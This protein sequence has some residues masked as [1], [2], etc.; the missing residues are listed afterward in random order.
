M[1]VRACEFGNQWFILAV[2]RCT[3]THSQLSPLSRWKV[4][5][6]DSLN[7]YKTDFILTSR[8]FNSTTNE[9][10][11]KLLERLENLSTLNAQLSHCTIQSRP[12]KLFKIQVAFS[13]NWGNFQKAFFFYLYFLPMTHVTFNFILLIAALWIPIETD[14]RKVILGRETKRFLK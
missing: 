4:S 5:C 14:K 11:S 8:G 6:C 2:L 3:F 13:G 12:Q 10:T 9:I 7:A 1:L